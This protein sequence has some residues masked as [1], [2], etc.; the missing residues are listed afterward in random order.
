MMAHRILLFFAEGANTLLVRREG[1]ELSLYLFPLWLLV[2]VGYW[3][4]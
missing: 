2:V 4:S 3:E 1:V